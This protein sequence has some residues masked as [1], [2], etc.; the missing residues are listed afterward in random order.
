MVVGSYQDKGELFDSMSLVRWESL[1]AGD[2]T[3]RT[4]TQGL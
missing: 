2:I 1:G 4:S 3:I